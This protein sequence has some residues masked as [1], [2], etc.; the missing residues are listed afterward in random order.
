MAIFENTVSQ[1]A[2][3]PRL[4]PCKF[5]SLQN[6]MK[7][8]DIVGALVRIKLLSFARLYDYTNHNS[9]YFLQIKVE[10]K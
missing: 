7:I 3:F 9:I 5:F 10:S 1:N 6:G 4:A 2:S 8:F